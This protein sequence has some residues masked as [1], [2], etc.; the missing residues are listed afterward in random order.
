MAYY[1]ELNENNIVLRVVAISNEDCMDENGNEVEQLGI[2]RCL[3]LF[4]TGNWKKT[5]YNGNIRKNYAGIGFF[6][7]E[8]RDAFIDQKPDGEGWFLDENTCIW[9]NLE[10]EAEI[11]RKELLRKQIEI[12]VTRV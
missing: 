7:D 11:E 3:E 6:Y 5:S 9:R 12:G 2:D 8:Q 1:A 10:I 4:K